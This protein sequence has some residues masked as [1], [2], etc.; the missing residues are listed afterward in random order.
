MPLQA[1]GFFAPASGILS[2]AHLVLLRVV[3]LLG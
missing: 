1:R 3:P 2:L